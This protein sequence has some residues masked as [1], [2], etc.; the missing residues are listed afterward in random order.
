MAFKTPSDRSP[1][2]AAAEESAYDVSWRSVPM[3]LGQSALLEVPL[4]VFSQTPSNICTSM[5]G[6][7][8]RAMMMPTSRVFRRHSRVGGCQHRSLSSEGAV[9]G[10]VIVGI[11]AAVKAE[12]AVAIAGQVFCEAVID[13]E[14]IIGVDLAAEVGIAAT[15]YIEPGSPWE[16]A[17]SESFNG[18]FEDELLN[19]EEF[20]TVKEAKVLRIIEWSATL[21]VRGFVCQHEFRRAQLVPAH[22]QYEDR[23]INYTLIISGTRIGGRSAWSARELSAAAE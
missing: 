8:L 18:K 7:P 14:I 5:I 3:P 20:S 19:R 6:A 22:E 10:E 15:L 23:A 1:A 21:G 4:R 17:Y 11:D 2:D 16:N 9:D 13:L 12:V